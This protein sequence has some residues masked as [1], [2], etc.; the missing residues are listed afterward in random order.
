MLLIVTGVLITV[1]AILGFVVPYQNLENKVFVWSSPDNSGTST[2]V[3]LGQVNSFWHRKI[4]ISEVVEDGDFF[5]SA[6]VFIV[7]D[8]NTSFRND[9]C[10]NDSVSELPIYSAGLRVSYLYKDSLFRY[11]ICI[12]NPANNSQPIDV[13]AHIFRMTGLDVY[14][15]YP[16]TG[17]AD[18]A[19]QNSSLAQVF[20]GDSHCAVIDL[21]VPENSFYFYGTSISSQE[22]SQSADYFCTILYQ[23]EEVD[24]PVCN[25]SDS[26]CVYSFGDGKV[27]NFDWHQYDIIAAVQAGEESD[28][29]ST[30]Y[31]VQM[32]RN[33]T[34]LLLVCIF[35]IVILF[36]LTFIVICYIARRDHRVRMLQ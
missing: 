5:H 31:N 16:M 18:S 10:G 14:E 34:F 13:Q 19:L 21:T 32:E 17:Q 24:D 25:V 9:S 4:S 8:H 35:T 3:W 27:I 2:T 12:N 33:Y 6:Q 36:I 11:R 15:D 30:H 20:P 1:A 28:P 22:P 23:V 26:L 29:P 7:R